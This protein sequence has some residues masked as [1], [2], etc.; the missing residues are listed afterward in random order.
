[1]MA[2]IKA[3]VARQLERVRAMERNGEINGE[4]A[5]ALAQLP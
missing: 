4:P 5:S 1:M 3:D 2:E